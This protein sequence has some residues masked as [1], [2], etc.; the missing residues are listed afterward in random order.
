MAVV[1]SLRSERG[2]NSRNSKTK[3]PTA[4]TFST[5]RSNTRELDKDGRE[6]RAEKNV[7]SERL[8]MAI[9]GGLALLVPVIIMTLVHGVTESLVTTSVAIV[10]FALALA[11]YATNTS[12]K[13]IL[14]ATAAYA[15]VLVV[16]IGASVT[17]VP[18]GPG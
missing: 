4:T 10:L 3:P 17:Q 11:V 18:S 12:G 14:A 16:F 2:P 8:W 7:F 6:A 9:F 1:E 5:N 13:D 15:A